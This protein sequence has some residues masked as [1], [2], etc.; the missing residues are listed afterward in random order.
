MPEPLTGL[1]SRS[2]RLAGLRLMLAGLLLAAPACSAQPQQTRLRA[3][4]AQPANV[5]ALGRS[6]FLAAGIP[7]LTQYLTG[8]D[9]DAV[10][11]MQGP[12]LLLA[13]GGA[14]QLPAMQW[15]IDQV[16]GCSGCDKRIDMVVLRASGAD[17]YNTLFQDFKGLDS[18]E[19]LL[20]QERAAALNP[21]VAERI[22]QAE[23]V[24]FAG[25]D[26]CQYLKLFAGTPVQ[27]ALQSLYARGGGIGGTSAGLA[28]QGGLIYDGCSGSITSETALANPFDGQISFSPGLFAWP[29]LAHTLTDTHFSQRDRMGRLA[30]FL[31]RGRQPGGVTRGLAV[32]EATA[33]GV[34]KGGKALVF[35]AHHAYLLA[36][37][38]PP[39][40]LQTAQPLS[41][42]GLR[43]WR[44][45]AGDSIDLMNPAPP[46]GYTVELRK[47]QFM[48]N[49]YAPPGAQP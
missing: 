1:N 48:Q 23:V 26:Q 27:K 31:A 24:F 39:A 45:S 21:A 2:C 10:V 15:L 12:A 7:G 13:G 28:I 9:A 40:M 16:R 41:W 35:G 17:G 33:L 46:G 47:G 44:F 49:P 8:S 6:R 29:M 22:S 43:L 3:Q 42:A 5:Q 11:P 18:L 20:I 36:P 37:A 30:V 25:G 38:G 19:T 14:D 4:G 32:D 34:D